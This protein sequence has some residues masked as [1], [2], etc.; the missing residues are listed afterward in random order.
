MLVNGCP[1][2]MPAVIGYHPGH[3]QDATAVRGAGDSA[4]AEWHSQ[5]AAWL[6]RDHAIAVCP[7]CRPLR[8]SATA[9]P[10]RSDQ[11]ADL[12]SVILRSIAIKRPLQKSG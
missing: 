12:V 3:E 4:A 6:A 8:R 11:G 7:P 10:K 2:I 5:A 9:K 1:S